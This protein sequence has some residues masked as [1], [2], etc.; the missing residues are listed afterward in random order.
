MQWDL[1]V[2]GVA[3]SRAPRSVERMLERRDASEIA[4]E[5]R[6][7][8]AFRRA[9]NQSAWLADE[10]IAAGTL[11][12]GRAPS[13]L[14]LMTGLTLIE[15][16]R[17]RRSKSLPRE[18]AL[19]VTRDRVVAFAL[20]RWTEGDGTTDHVV[21]IKRGER[22]S[23]P[24]QSVRIVDLTERGATLVLEGVERIPLTSDGDDSANELVEVLSRS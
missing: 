17:P 4:V 20:S 6:A 23:W 1:V 2:D 5:F 9:L 11:R 3:A 22:G 21:K 24:R 15:A 18:F 19:A 10:V 12:Q 14:E 7:P 13:L 8:G 16:A